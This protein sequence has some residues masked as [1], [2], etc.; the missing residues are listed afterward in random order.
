MS[1]V[2]LHEVKG[3]FYKIQKVHLKPWDMCAGKLIVEEA[4]GLVTDFDGKK[5]D[6][7]SKKILA[8][9]GK[10]HNSMIEVLKQS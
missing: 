6:I 5:I 9:N 2:L 10:V 4:G 8:S 3:K 7:F 1:N